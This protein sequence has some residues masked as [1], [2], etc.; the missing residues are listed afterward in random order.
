MKAKLENDPLL[1]NRGV[2]IESETDEEKQ[3]LLQ[4]WYGHGG[5]AALTRNDDGTVTLVI[6]ATAAEIEKVKS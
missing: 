3:V 2:E 4:L 6:A 1:L 5:P